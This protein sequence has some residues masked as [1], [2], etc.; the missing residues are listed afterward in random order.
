MTEPQPRPVDTST[1][2]P[3]EIPKESFEGEYELRKKFERDFPFYASKYLHILD[4][5]GGVVKFEFNKA[6][7]YIHKQL[8]DQKRRTGKVRALILKARQEGA[9]T[10][11]AG[12]FYHRVTHRFGVNA[13]VLSHAMDTTKKLF[14]MTRRY[15]DKAEP[16]FRQKTTAASANE[17]VF[18]I[19]D[20]SYFVGTAGA[21]ATGRGG[22]IHFFHGSEVAFWPDAESHFAGVMQSIPTG[23][24]SAGTEVIL[25]STANG[26][27]GKFYDLCMKAQKG[28]GEYILIFTPWYWQDEYRDTPP[29]GWS[30]DKSEHRDMLESAGLQYDLDEEQLYWM[31]LKIDELGSEWLFKQEYPGNVEEAFQ[32]SGDESY[33]PS[34]V[35]E[36]ARLDK[37]DEIRDIFKKPRI[38]A[39]DPAG[40]SENADRTGIGHICGRR[41]EN[42]E[43]Y[44][45]KDSVALAEIAKQYIRKWGITVMFIDV[46]GMGVGV[47]DI[48]INDGYRRTVRPCNFSNTPTD[49]NPDGSRKYANKR[50][51]CWGRMLTWLKDKPCEI[52]NMEELRVDLTGPQYDMD[53]GF[54]T[55]ESKRKM[56]TR[57]VKSPDGADV[58]SM[59]F[60]E[61]VSG[62]L[63]DRGDRVRVI[64]EYDEMS[65]G[66]GAY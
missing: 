54:L 50:A 29:A 27:S 7:R 46:N 19:L 42:L 53:K 20:S 18:S 4:K 12:R 21:K 43:Y 59:C 13:Y 26:P 28:E 41:M 57:G 24:L 23:K 56:K 10:Y 64:T 36:Y 22:T 62:R 63:R 6:Q 31:G 37:G 55:L 14:N 32:T 30:I 52:P 66:I 40:A 9:S 44:R 25:E 5:G 65:Y 3:V 61:H 51:E 38:A 8:E 35:V 1:L 34:E 11:V 15:H 60:T 48:L 2:T 17:F 45:G 47:Y 49:I 58:L 33:I 39:L 16:P